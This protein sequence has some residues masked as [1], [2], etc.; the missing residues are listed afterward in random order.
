MELLSQFSHNQALVGEDRQLT[1]FKW[2]WVMLQIGDL[3]STLYVFHLGGY[4]ANPLVAKLLPYTGPI[5][6]IVT[7]KA[8]GCSLVV[9]MRSRKML[10]AGL[11]IASCI[12]SWNIIVIAFGG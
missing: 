1:W 7:M 3:L 8:I 11:I 4:E 9:P 12:L 5:G 6:G 2:A 10:S